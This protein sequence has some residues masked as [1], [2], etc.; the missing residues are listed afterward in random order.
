M[1]RSDYDYA[2]S[3]HFLLNGENLVINQEPEA[4]EIKVPTSKEELDVEIFENIEVKFK[5]LILII[6]LICFFYDKGQETSK[7]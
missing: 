7:C 1:D 5:L 3:L 2:L 6:Q 4:D